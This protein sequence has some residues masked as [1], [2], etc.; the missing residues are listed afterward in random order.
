MFAVKVRPDVCSEILSVSSLS[1]RN[2]TAS[3]AAVV[4]IRSALGAAA[5]AFEI[6]KV[7]ACGCCA[8]WARHFEFAGFETILHEAE[9]VAAVRAAASVSAGLG[10][11]HT[12][13]VAGYAVEDHAPVMAVQRLL[14]ERPAVLGLA[15]PGMPLG[16]PGME[17]EGEPGEPYDV[18]AF[19]PDGSRPVFMAVRP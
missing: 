11:C 10:G 17:S 7:R 8:A 14:A 2:L 18:I 1:C 9:D 6:W 15:V 12:G 16:S 4:L 5:D 13:K 3:L 19:T